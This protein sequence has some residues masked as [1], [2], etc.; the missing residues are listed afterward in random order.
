MNVATMFRLACN[1]HHDN[2]IYVLYSNHIT[3]L[4]D[5]LYQRILVSY[6][7]AA[8]SSM[9]SEIIARSNLITRRKTKKTPSPSISDYDLLPLGKT[10]DIVISTVLP[11]GCAALSGSG[12]LLGAQKIIRYQLNITF[13]FHFLA[14]SFT[15]PRYTTFHLLF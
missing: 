8:F 13:Y 9:S 4:I 12:Y 10:R 14:E 3:V 6:R 1:D 7:F 11:R 15:S 2:C 5:L